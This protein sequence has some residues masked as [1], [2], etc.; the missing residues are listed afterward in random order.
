MF[1]KIKYIVFKI[2]ILTASFV[3]PGFHEIKFIT[4]F[5]EKAELF[6]SFFANQCSLIISPSFLPTNCENLT[7]KS[8]SNITFTDN[9]IGKIIKTLDPNKAHGHNVISIRILKLYCGSIY[10]PLRLIFRPLRL[11]L[12]RSRDFPL[13][14]EKSERCSYS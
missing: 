12:F 1:C 7:D 8:L 4:D 14:L 3:R 9:D 11:I 13:V 6:N 2:K 5:R 10:K